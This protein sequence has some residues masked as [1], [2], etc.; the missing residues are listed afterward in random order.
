[1]A[2]FNSTVVPLL[3]RKLFYVSRPVNVI[4]TG[5]LRQIVGV[6]AM[7]NRRTDITGVLAFTGGHFAQLIEG[8]PDAVEALASRIALDTRHAGF[9]VLLTD[10]A[11]VQREFTS[12]EMQLVHSPAL[13]DAIGT[14]LRGPGVDPV[15]AADALKRICDEARWQSAEDISGM[16]ARSRLG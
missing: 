5:E 11:P 15:L 10:D 13:D 14:L 1:M 8:A 12:W 4:T 16:A 6:A 9:K 3:L 2:R 7:S